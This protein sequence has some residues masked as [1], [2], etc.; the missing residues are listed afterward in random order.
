[1]EARTSLHGDAV[2]LTDGAQT[3]PHPPDA[4]WEPTTLK[5]NYIKVVSA[6]FSFFVAGVN[7]GS[8]GALIPYLI[9][10]YDINT[11]MISIVYGVTFFGWFIA[12][13]TNSHL[14]QYLDLGAML[15][16]GAFLQVLAHAL[17]C[18]TP[19]FAL[20]AVT[21][22]IV[23]LGQA[24]QDT[25]ANTFVASVK[26]AHRFLGLIHAMYSGG[27][28]VG[29]FVSTAIASADTPSRWNLFYTFP[30]ALGVLNLLLC[31]FA[32]RDSL[33][34]KTKHATSPDIQGGSR[35]DGAMAEIKETLKTPS[36]WLLSLFYFFYLGVIITA[37]GWVVEYLV[38]VRGGDLADMGYVPAGFNGGSFLGRLLLAEPT[39]RWGERRMLFI[40]SV[41]GVALQLLFWLVPNIIA[42]SVAISL[43]GFVLG[44]FFAAGISV[45]SKLF[46]DKVRSSA[47][48]LVF[49]LGQIGG[50][51]FPAVTGIVA[52]HAG[53]KVLQPVLVALMAATGV[54]WLFVPKTGG[55]H[56]R[57]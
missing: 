21:F 2:E 5:T 7:D 25:H 30:L 26:T 27:C 18:W 48:A 20:F 16:L 47:L 50:S 1:M 32:F 46:S 6:A 54:S 34:I 11:A 17:R 19:P 56:H 3:S 41:I 29:P 43:M 42:A 13:V 52:A 12:A 22:G 9:R 53:V 44:P 10:S 40:Y 38:E 15:V 33:A 23:S 49:V 57:E 8:L 31:I 24:Y 37:S 35:N 55:L 28:L 45:G 14:C 4:D 39:H 36:V 51:I